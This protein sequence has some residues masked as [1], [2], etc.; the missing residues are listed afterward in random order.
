MKATKVYAIELLFA[1][2]PQ[3]EKDQAEALCDRLLDGVR[4]Y[5]TS[6]GFD[7]TDGSIRSSTQLFLEPEPGDDVTQ[8]SRAYEKVH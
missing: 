4:E 7:V 8:L 5:L 1:M 2:E 3:I 6:K